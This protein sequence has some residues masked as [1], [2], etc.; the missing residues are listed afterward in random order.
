[1]IFTS[2]NKYSLN[3]IIATLQEYE[4]QSGQQINKEKNAFFFIKV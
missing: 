2:T 4:V 3:K 1:M